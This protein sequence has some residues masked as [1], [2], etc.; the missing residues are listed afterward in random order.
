M[1]FFIV[2]Y[3]VPVLPIVAITSIPFLSNNNCRLYISSQVIS[4]WI[5]R[6]LKSRFISFL[7]QIGFGSVE[8]VYSLLCI[9]FATLEANKFFA[10]FFRAPSSVFCHKNVESTLMVART[11]VT[12]EG[13]ETSAVAHSRSKKPLR[14]PHRSSPLRRQIIFMD[15]SQRSGSSYA[16]RSKF[17]K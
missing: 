2:V 13:Y 1:I 5:N 7:M 11:K 8:G 9:R 10:D 16:D 15:C 6:S 17:H 14:Q 3:L 12:D 4:M